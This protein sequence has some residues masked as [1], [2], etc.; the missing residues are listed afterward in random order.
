M[1]EELETMT[2]A[3]GAEQHSIIDVLVVPVMSLTA[4]EEARKAMATRS[5]FFLPF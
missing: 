4:V 2:Q 1:Q 3:F 5:V